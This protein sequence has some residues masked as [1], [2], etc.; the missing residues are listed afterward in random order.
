MLPPPSWLR[1]LQLDA[2]TKPGAVL[3]IPVAQVPDPG[4][5]LPRRISFD[6]VED[7]PPFVLPAAVQEESTPTFPMIN[8]ATAT[9]QLEEHLVVAV[10]E[11]P[12]PEKED[13]PEPPYPTYV[14]GDYLKYLVSFGNKFTAASPEGCPKVKK[15]LDFVANAHRWWANLR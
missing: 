14:M 3:G 15:Y 10:A 13:V 1:P 2:P 7:V 12:V 9:P 5:F 6:G 11:E 4:V 8:T